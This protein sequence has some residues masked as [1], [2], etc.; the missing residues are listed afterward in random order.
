MMRKQAVIV[1]GGPAGLAAA[2]R[3]KEPDLALAL[4]LP[5]DP[6][7]PLGTVLGGDGLTRLFGG[8][9]ATV[10]LSMPRWTMR[11]N[12]QLKP[13]LTALGMP[14]AFDPETLVDFKPISL[15]GLS[16]VGVGST[17]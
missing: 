16:F 17:K 14:T 8:G 12:R 15:T 9:R 5:T 11:F 2:L 6:T 10:Q 13:A 1:G 7:A 4:I 3:L